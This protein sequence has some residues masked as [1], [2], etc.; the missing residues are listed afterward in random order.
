MT[1][2][3]TSGRFPASEM[4]PMLIAY[5]GRPVMSKSIIDVIR[6]SL[7][8]IKEKKT[9]ASLPAWKFVLMER[10]DIWQCLR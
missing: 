10:K 8:L 4:T 2:A 7:D 6:K 9:N 1:P 5:N 3:T